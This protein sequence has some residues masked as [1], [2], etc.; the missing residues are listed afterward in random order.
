MT[1][2]GRQPVVHSVGRADVAGCLLLHG[3]RAGSVLTVVLQAQRLTQL[4]V[5][6]LEVAVKGNPD[7][8]SWCPWASG[9]R[10]P[11]P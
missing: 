10:D 4:Q 1:D 8:G 9:G 11:Y 3:F 2:Q 5:G 7:L 6:R